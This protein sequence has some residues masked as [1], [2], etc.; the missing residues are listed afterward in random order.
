MWVIKMAIFAENWIG[1]CTWDWSYLL[2]SVDTALSHGPCTIPSK[3]E[4]LVVLPPWPC[5]PRKGQPY[6][7]RYKLLPLLYIL[8]V[9]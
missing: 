3:T 7:L 6:L 9:L 8:L 5:F 2:T 1:Q 4:P